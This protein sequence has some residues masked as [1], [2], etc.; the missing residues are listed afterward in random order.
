[1]GLQRPHV[2]QSTTGA[3]SDGSGSAVP[4]GVSAV[5]ATGGVLVDKATEEGMDIIHTAHSS[6]KSS[7][8]QFFSP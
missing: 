8:G 5:S 7:N 4:V 6:S 3:L 1:M 2:H